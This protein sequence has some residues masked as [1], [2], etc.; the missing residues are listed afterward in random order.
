M[1]VHINVGV[2]D[3][4]G[5]AKDEVEGKEVQ[6]GWRGQLPKGAEHVLAGVLHSHLELDRQKAEDEE[7][8]VT[9]VDQSLVVGLS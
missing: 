9:N 1:Q 2:L 5:Q 8:G 7:A 6:G 3:A 4:P